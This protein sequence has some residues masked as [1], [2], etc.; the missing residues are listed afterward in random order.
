MN[1]HVYTPLLT[2]SG[3]LTSKALEVAMQH[4]ADEHMSKDKEW[5][6]REGERD[7]GK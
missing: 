1:R 6:G 7:D 4:D 2:F 3:T 5:T